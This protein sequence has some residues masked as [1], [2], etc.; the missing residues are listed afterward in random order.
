MLVN[1]PRPNCCHRCESRTIKAHCK[2]KGCGWAE[3]KKCGAVSCYLMRKPDNVS[4]V[5]APSGLWIRASF[6]GVTREGRE[7]DTDTAG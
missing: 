4:K 7:A 6:G 2:N 1:R 5:V 3:C